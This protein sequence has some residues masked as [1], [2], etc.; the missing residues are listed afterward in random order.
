MSIEEFLHARLNEDEAWARETE[1]AQD[2]D[3]AF[4][5]II[6]R[7]WLPAFPPGKPYRD[8]WPL[9]GEPRLVLREVVAKRAIIE[10]AADANALDVQVDGE[11]GVGARDELADP[12]VGDLILRALAAVHSDRRDY[13]PSWA[14]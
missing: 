3:A 6:V 8:P 12:H 1:A 5:H 7:R 10:H 11:W 2:R 9:P 4:G 13:D 14:L